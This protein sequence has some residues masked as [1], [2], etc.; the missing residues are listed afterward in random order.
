MNHQKFKTIFNQSS[1]TSQSQLLKSFNKTK[2]TLW[3]NPTNNLKLLRSMRT[4]LKWTS[5]KF[6]STMQNP[7][8]SKKTPTNHPKILTISLSRN[9]YKVF[10]LVNLN[11]SKMKSLNKPNSK[12]ILLPGQLNSQRYL[13]TPKPTINKSISLH[14]YKPHKLLKS[15][16]HSAF[17]L[18]VL[19]P[20]K[21]LTMNKNNMKW[22]KML[23]SNKST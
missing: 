5:K 8:R 9:T 6:N 13:Q 3:S 16:T 21:K 11:K 19:N 23:N 2:K 10:R 22:S 1:N 14:S 12:T 18:I 7:N 17:Q 20:N 4:F 15:L